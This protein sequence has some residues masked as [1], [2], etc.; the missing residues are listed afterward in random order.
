MGPR[1]A[2]TQAH[3][4]Q[5]SLDPRSSLNQAKPGRILANG[6]PGF[7][8]SYPIV[9]TPN[10]TAIPV[11]GLNYPP[12]D[13]IQNTRGLH[14]TGALARTLWRI[15]TPPGDSIRI[16]WGLRGYT[17]RVHSRAP[18]GESKHPP[19]DSIRITRGLGGYC[20]GPNTGVPKEEELITIKR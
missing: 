18:S 17:R 9:K 5:G 11:K 4:P 8:L 15:E 1:V 13:S 10:L 6:I 3:E 12:G 16:T 7:P 2:K 19:G 14:P 20:R